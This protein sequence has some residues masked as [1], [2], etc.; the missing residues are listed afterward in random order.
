MEKRQISFHLVAS[1]VI[2]SLL[3][4]ISFGTWWNDTWSSRSCIPVSGVDTAGTYYL[5]L[6]AQAS[7]GDE[8]RW[9]TNASGT[10]DEVG[11]FWKIDNESL[12]RYIVNTTLAAGTTQLCYYYGNTSVVSISPLNDIRRGCNVGD[13]FNDGSLNTT[14]WTQYNTANETGGFVQVFGAVYTAGLQSKWNTT[15]QNSTVIFR[16]YTDRND[17]FVAGFSSGHTYATNEALLYRGSTRFRLYVH[18]ATVDGSRDTNLTTDSNWRNWEIFWGNPTD[19]VSIAYGATSRMNNTANSPSVPMG[20]SVFSGGG[21][22]Y[23]TFI[24]WICAY[25]LADSDGWDFTTSGWA[26]ESNPTISSCPHTISSAGEYT[27]NSDLVTTGSCVQIDA[28]DVLIDC[29]GHSITGDD[30]TTDFAFNATG[31]YNNIT[32]QN[33]TVRD[34]GNAVALKNVNRSIIQ[35]NTFDSTS[36]SAI[37]TEGIYLL[38]ISYNNISDSVR[39]IRLN[40]DSDGANISFNDIWGSSDSGLKIEGLT[41]NG[42]FTYSNTIHSCDYGIYIDRGLFSNLTYDRIYNSTYYDVYMTSSAA[43]SNGTLNISHMTLDRPAGDMTG[44]SYFDLTDTIVPGTRYGIAWANETLPNGYMSIGDRHMIVENLLGSPEIELFVQRYLDTDYP[45][46]FDENNILLLKNTSGTWSDPSAALDTAA[47]TLTLTMF[48][49]FSSFHPAGPAFNIP[50]ISS[51]VIGP[52]PPYDLD[53]LWCSFDTEDNDTAALD[54]DVEWYDNGAWAYTESWSGTTANASY[55]STFPA[56]LTT[57]YHSYYCQINTTDGTTWVADNSSNITVLNHAPYGSPSVYPAAPVFHNALSCNT[58]VSDDD[59]NAMSGTIAWFNGTALVSAYTTSFLAVANGTEVDS[60]VPSGIT[61]P[62][63]VWLCELN[64]TDGYNRTYTNSSSVTILAGVAP[65]AV[66]TLD[67]AFPF[68]D[69]DVLCEAVLSDSDSPA[70]DGNISFLLNGVYSGVSDTYT[71]AVS[72]QLISLTI[73]E[74]NISYGDT[75][76]CLVYISDGYYNSTSSSSLVTILNH[77]VPTNITANI[78][79]AGNYTYGGFVAYAIGFSE[80]WSVY[81]LVIFIYGMAFMFTRRY[82]Q[83]FIL[84]GVGCIAAYTLTGQ[85]L[86]VPAGILSI[87]LGLFY[88]QV[89]G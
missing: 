26:N 71:G 10:E 17:G 11:G 32:I 60:V 39:G 70:L 19:N 81:I 45:T 34:F 1:V 49:N 4:Q 52:S 75:L 86:F 23:S 68:D 87:T 59:A 35:N 8:I 77:T 40:L 84:G 36:G 53:A 64:V 82:P 47:N 85:L 57:P 12:N 41:S 67:P 7:Y 51:V 43:P 31:S 5:N 16:G 83:T 74:G 54:I 89:V 33:C 63:E 44:W 66:V 58:T 79:L 21:A 69:D 24:D 37:Y 48:S 2:L 38:N 88:K 9:T 27:L 78:T 65:S 46:G 61:W 25:D 20:V 14:I 29:M 42:T 80:D 13:D 62:D 72:G 3:P 30:D 56:A 15:A 50:V 22:T 73:A 18:T 28:S 6:S 76:S 55:N